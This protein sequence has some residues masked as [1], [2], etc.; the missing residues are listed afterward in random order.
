MNAT[1]SD[2]KTNLKLNNMYSKQKDHKTRAKKISICEN[3]AINEQNDITGWDVSEH[4]ESE[5]GKI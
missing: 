5:I 1:M 3:T 4:T 2:I